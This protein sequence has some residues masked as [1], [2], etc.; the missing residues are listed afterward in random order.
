VGT[1][2]AEA[3]TY[4]DKLNIEYRVEEVRES[5][6][7][8]KIAKRYEDNFR[9]VWLSF[10]LHAWGRSGGWRNDEADAMRSGGKATTWTATQGLATG[11]PEGPGKFVC[12]ARLWS[13]WH[14][15]SCHHCAPLG[16]CGW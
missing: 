8:V 16:V 13:P 15:S 3:K 1:R 12:A 7:N 14:M 11:L 9:Y 5:K 4:C 6:T 2:R 10:L